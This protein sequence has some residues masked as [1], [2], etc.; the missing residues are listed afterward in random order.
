MQLAWGITHAQSTGYVYDAN[1]R[2]VAVTA[3]NGA[4]VQYTYNSLG[5]ASQV[6]APVPSGQLAIF[7]FMPTHGQ[8]GTQV[9]I[10]GQGFDSNAAND[11]VNFN[12]AVATVLSASATQLVVA[13][14]SGATTGP[15]SASVGNQTAA[16]SI[17]FVVDDSGLPPT[18][19]QVSPALVSVGNTVTVMGTHLD[20]AAG[21][22][23]VR[24]AGSPMTVTSATDSQLQYVVPAAGTSGFVTV[25]TPYGHATSSVPLIVLP[26]GLSA[27]N[28][29]DSVY[30]D[31]GGSADIAI[32]AS[33]KTG[34]LLF[35]GGAGDWISLQL[36]A[37]STAANAINYAVYAPGNQLIQQ[38]TVSA[39]APSIHLPQLT[40]A[41]NYLVTF[42][43]DTAAATFTVGVERAAVLAT[44][45]PLTL[46]MAVQGQSKRLLFQGTA[47][48]VMTLLASGTTTTPAGQ[49]LSYTVYGPRQQQVVVT[50]S[51]ATNGS[52]STPVLS[53]TGVYQVIVSPGSGVTASTQVELVA[54]DVIVANWPI[55]HHG[56]YPVG[57][58]AQVTFTANQGD[59]LELTLSN[60]TFGVDGRFPMTVN[61]LDAHG[62]NIASGQCGQGGT[63][64][65]ALWNLAQG[66]YSVVAT[67][68]Y[69]F[70]SIAGFDA[71]LQPD[72]VGPA[73]SLNTAQ[74]ATLAQ[75]QVE[76]FTFNGNAGDNLALNIANVSTANGTQQPVTFAVYRPDTS[77]IT[78][79]NA[80][81]TTSFTSSGI[82]NI[83]NLP[84]S[85][86]YTVIVSTSGVAATAQLTLTPTTIAENGQSAHYGGYLPGQSAG[87]SFT[88]NQG[89]NLELTVSNV[90]F[91]V[92]GRFPMTVNVL[93][94]HGTNI[95]SGQCGQ[96]GTCRF[97]LWN[98]AQGSYS[99]VAT[100]IYTFYSIAGF[101]A[102]LQ[103]DAVGP[104]LS[105]NT[106]QT[107][108]LA[109]GQVERFTFNGNAG[110]NLALNIA[111]V[112]TANGT[113]QP[114]TFAVYRPDTSPITTT[115]AY[116][117]TSFTSSGILNIPNLPISGTYTVIVST[118]GVAATAQLALTPTTIAENGQSA[119]YGG[120]LPGQ[121]AGISFTANQGDNLELTL[122]NVTF[123]VDGRFP[124]TVNVLDAHGTN[125]AS[126]QCGQ[127]G[128]CRF[129]LWNL[130]QG[131]Y[132]VVATPI[133]TFYSIAGFDAV[134][135]SDTVGPAL[136]LNTAQTATLAQGQVERFTF[137]GNAGDN[138]ALNIANVSTANGTQQPVTFAVYRPDTS[139]ITTTNAYLT[140]SF[141]SS[142]ILNIPNLPISGTYT[143]I[144]STSGVA[145]TA[146]LALT[147]TTIA[148]NGQSAHY[149]GYLPGQ[150]AGISFTANQGDNL[151]LTLSNVTFGVDGRFPMTVKVLDASG[152]TI[153]SGQCGQGGTCRFALWNLTQG[154]YNVVATPMYTFYSIAGFDAVLQSDT[155]GPSLSLNTAQ[156]AT[157][158]QGQVER[159]T[160]NG[161]AGDNRVLNVAGVS[162][163]SPTGQPIT[164]AVYR[165]DNA[166]TPGNAY[167]S[168]QYT[169]SGSLSMTNLPV[170]GTYTVVVSTAGEPGSAQLTMQ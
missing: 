116:L 80:Y 4:S 64:R 56:G 157:L 143:V 86:T 139:P 155:V 38:G 25:A 52:I 87:I 10:Q 159:F 93:D 161:N 46:A 136:S 145:A 77:P 79:T 129:A 22:T 156:T 61:V 2:V 106:A 154:S 104:A 28:V 91:G 49:S 137:N 60:V 23:I 7:A 36:K 59:N 115:N 120:Y 20:P 75:G 58:S 113:Q 29:V 124:M 122:S 153:V 62:T 40:V 41:G 146:Q 97:A 127:G 65:F 19:A 125:I 101:D 45:T 67:P 44:G 35:Q 98:L 109:Q 51:I 71:V 14:P 138:L 112:S 18:I 169:D 158:A 90:T 27:A 8:S 99:V 140:T 34:T 160:F 39:S 131:S 102:V 82:L 55:S 53:D 5:H 118:S 147:P 117:T 135:Q 89:D 92:D 130:A 12:G 123:G 108:T 78:T 96:G 73:L 162:T 164:F 48:Q 54:G 21:E 163:T 16:S 26:S 149:G 15:I 168:S 57:K 105:L 9:T 110:D 47:G 170:S 1:G 94:A 17:P 144:V 119:H 133:Y 134:L 33:G 114:V 37:I 43:P 81:L 132:S 128:T 85:G 165:P 83:P 107:A 6:S 31:V 42:T 72:A 167:V 103:P 50:G 30:T 150:S 11:T 13:V 74:T 68:I 76:R 126:G 100:P 3:S 66:S 142:G 151:E 121:S 69:T 166:I 141:T 70:Y 88:A 32:P 63:C 95:A 84:I 111:N 148:E 24:M 152:A